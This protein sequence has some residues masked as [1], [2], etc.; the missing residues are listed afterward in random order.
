M[1]KPMNDAIEAAGGQTALAQA[2][3][4]KPSQVWQ[5]LNE[6]RGKRVPPE[7]CAAIEAH[8]GVKCETLRPDID[9]HRKRG[10]VTGY[11]TPVAA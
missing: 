10:K 11:F 2:I 9:W 4:A 7:Y 1:H 6:W 3:N 8:T 5:W